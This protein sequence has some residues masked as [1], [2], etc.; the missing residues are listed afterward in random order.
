M[1]AENKKVIG[2][3]VWARPDLFERCAGLPVLK[4]IRSITSSIIEGLLNNS[5]SQKVLSIGIGPGIMYDV[6]KEEILAGRLNLIGIDILP[7]ML[8][9]AS[10]NLGRQNVTLIEKDI[11]ENLSL[12]PKSVNI[13]EAGLVLHHVLEGDELVSIFRQINQVLIKNGVFILGDIDVAIGEHI[14]AKLQHLRQTYPRVSID[15]ETGEFVCSNG[16]QIRLK[17]LDSRNVEDQGILKNMT[18]TTCQP[19]EDEMRKYNASLSD[20]ILANTAN[21]RKGLEWHRSIKGKH[22]WISLIKK[23]FEATPVN[24]EIIRPAEIKRRFS[25]VLDN[26]FVVVVRKL[27]S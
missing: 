11:R 23:G 20:A 8:A 16:N 1:C 10:Q 2:V 21:A 12:P 22:G 26:P 19:L 13:A 5:E 9:K 7:E 4:S 6:F 15:L 27:D 3:G 14:E 24:I 17:I 18:V 25:N